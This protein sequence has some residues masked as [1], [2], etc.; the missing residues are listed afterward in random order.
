MYDFYTCDYQSNTKHKFSH[1][2]SNAL[3]AILFKN[4]RFLTL[5]CLIRLFAI[6]VCSTKPHYKKTNV[7]GASF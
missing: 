1:I 5:Q 2:L 3:P 6:S 7:P 4:P